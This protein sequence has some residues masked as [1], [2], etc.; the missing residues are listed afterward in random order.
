MKRKIGALLMTAAITGSCLTLPASAAMSNFTNQKTYSNSFKDLSSGSWYYDNVVKAYQLGLMNGRTDSAF[1]PSGTLSIAETITLLS[2]IHAK[3][4]GVII[5]SNA[6][7]WYA[8]YVKYATENQI[9]DATYQTMTDAEINCPITR[10]DFAQMLYKTLPTSEFASINTVEKNGIIDMASNTQGASAIYALYQAGIITGSGTEKA[11]LPNAAISRAE[12][13]TILARVIDASV[14]QTVEL[15]EGTSDIIDYNDEALRLEAA[16][17]AV[18]SY[19]STSDSQF[20][21][22]SVDAIDALSNASYLIT[23]T[24]SHTDG[25]SAQEFVTGFMQPNGV[26]LITKVA[27]D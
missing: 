18:D 20:K 5:G 27:A 15:S 1:S 24:V 11:F 4:S 22:V 23:V 16:T 17:V 12:T 13:A 14:R 6:G 10:Y 2:R 25:G 7:A 21:A 3:Y 9:I 8:P 19:F 26:F